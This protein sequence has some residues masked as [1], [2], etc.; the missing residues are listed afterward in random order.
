MEPEFWQIA[1]QLFGLVA[2]VGWIWVGVARFE[3]AGC[4]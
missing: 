4:E 1:D 3:P 2:V